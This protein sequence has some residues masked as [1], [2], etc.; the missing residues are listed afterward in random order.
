MFLNRFSMGMDKQTM[1]Y[2]YNA[3]LSKYKKE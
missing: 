2:P 3:I 1:V